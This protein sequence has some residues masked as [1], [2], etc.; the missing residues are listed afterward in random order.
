MAGRKEIK[1]SS[2]TSR[3]VGVCDLTGGAAR[4]FIDRPWRGEPVLLRSCMKASKT[5]IKIE[6]G[7]GECS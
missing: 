4:W 7:R 3:D 1:A 2:T 6:R 5:P